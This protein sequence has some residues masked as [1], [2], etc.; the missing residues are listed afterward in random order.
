MPFLWNEWMRDMTEDSKQFFQSL[1]T[2]VAQ[3]RKDQGLTQQQ[4]AEL[5]ELSQQ[6]IASYEVG[7]LRMPL[8]L[9][10]RLAQVLHVQVEDLLADQPRSSRRGGPTGKAR[11]VFEQVSQ[12]PRHQQQK[13][14]AVVEALV[15]QQSR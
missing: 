9:L 13:I 1:G 12:L 11:R 14:I 5:L 10:P 4:L 7:R 3:C 2:R 6:L 8:S 15:A